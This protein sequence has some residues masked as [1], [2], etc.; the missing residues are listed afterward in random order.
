LRSTGIGP[1]SLTLFSG[2]HRF[3]NGIMQAE[4]GVI[5]RTASDVYVGP[6]GVDK[7][8]HRCAFFRRVLLLAGFSHIAVLM[9]PGVFLLLFLLIQIGA[10]VA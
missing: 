2:I 9:I 3:L 4:F 10:N 8:H 5:H 6:S 7:G 1:L